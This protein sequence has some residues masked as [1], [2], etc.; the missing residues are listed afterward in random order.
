MAEVVSF[1]DPDAAFQKYLA[2][3]D[4]NLTAAITDPGAGG[5]ISVANSGILLLAGG[6]GGTWTLPAPTFVGQSMTIV[7]VSYTHLRAH[8]T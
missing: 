2:A 1:T 7:P 8:E 6:T 3:I 5:T 4:E